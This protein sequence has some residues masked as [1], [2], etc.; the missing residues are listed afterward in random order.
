MA[1]AMVY[2]RGKSFLLEDE[3]A[4]RQAKE[5]PPAGTA[6]DTSIESR[7]R[8]NSVVVGPAEHL[9]P[10]EPFS[11][12]LSSVEIERRSTVLVEETKGV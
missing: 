12:P 6:H 2:P 4:N 11:G 3:D 1:A 5:G 7:N 10:T 8:P 9:A